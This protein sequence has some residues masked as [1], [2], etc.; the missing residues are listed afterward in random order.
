MD[1][2]RFLVISV[3]TGS[4]KNE[5]KYDARKASKWG[6]L[7][8]LY[9]DNST[10]L[11]DSFFQASVDVVDFHNAVVFEA[12]HSQN[13]YLRIQVNFNKKKT[14]VTLTLLLLLLFNSGVT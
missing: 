7:G 4:A 9:N 12:L 5:E 1:L 3:G 11:I 13:N 14:P 8:W 6:V 2:G 10:P